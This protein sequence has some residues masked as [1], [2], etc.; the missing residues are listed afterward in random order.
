M[1]QDIEVK[2]GHVAAEPAAE[3]STFVLIIQDDPEKPGEVNIGGSQKPVE[4]DRTSPSHVIGAWIR[5]H[6]ADI[7]LAAR[8]EHLEQY[9][10]EDKKLIDG[11]RERTILL[12]S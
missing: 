6:L 7:V 9:G 8:Q 3:L 2:A 1:T 11:D 5:D 10:I 12:P 4:F